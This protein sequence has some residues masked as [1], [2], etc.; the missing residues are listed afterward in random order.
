MVVSPKIGMEVL[1]RIKESGIRYVF[2]QPGSYN[3]EII[4]KA[5]K[6]ELEYLTGDCVYAT[7]RDME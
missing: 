2:F 3:E 4:K 5:E 1:D 6:L 7:L